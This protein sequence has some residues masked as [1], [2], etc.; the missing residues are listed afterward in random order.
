MGVA[1][2]EKK[3]KKKKKKEVDLWHR[4]CRSMA[5]LSPVPEPQ[6]SPAPLQETSP[7]KGC[8][9]GSLSC[10]SLTPLGCCLQGLAAATR[11]HSTLPGGRPEGYPAPGQPRTLNPGGDQAFYS[12]QVKE[13]TPLRMQGLEGNREMR[14]SRRRPLGVQNDQPQGMGYLA[15]GLGRGQQS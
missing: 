8:P 4:P 15:R 7:P 3:T 9:P 11:F 13:A 14:S 1:K 10:Q 5:S 6:Q 12:S 2:I